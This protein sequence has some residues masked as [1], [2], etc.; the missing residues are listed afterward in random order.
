MQLDIE[1]TLEEA[2]GLEALAVLK[3]TTP[4][5]I[6]Q[7]FASEVTGSLRTRGSDERMYAEQWFERT[8]MRF[9]PLTDAEREKYDRLTNQAYQFR[10]KGR[11]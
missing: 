2:A 3:A 10:Q 7:Q 8:F 11:A 6:L 4:K 5:K 9:N 1:L